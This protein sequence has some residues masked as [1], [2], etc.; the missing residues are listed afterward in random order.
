MFKRNL[1]KSVIIELQ[2]NEL[3]KKYLKVDCEK[4]EV[5]FAIRPNNEIGFYH[6]GG[7]LFSFDEKNK[8]R[9]HFKYASVIN[10]TNKDYLTEVE[11]KDYKLIS[12]FC[13]NYS[14]IKENCKHYSGVED[15]GIS[16]V[17]RKH[18][19]FSYPSNNIIVL[20]IEV[21][22]EAI[23][24]TNGRKQDIIDILLFDTNTQ[25]LK[26]IEAKHYSNS[27]IWAENIPKVINQIKRYE[28]QIAKKKTEIIKAYTEYVTTINE[29]FKKNIPLPEKIEEKVTLL[30]FGFDRDQQKGRLTKLIL[31]KEAYKGY[32]VYPIG[33]IKKI[34]L[35]NLW[36]VK[37]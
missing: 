31:E 20:D 8:F 24:K 19:F 21:A 25:T 30:I 28:K 36:K 12:D 9:T 18:S 11:L 16:E 27:E 14:R 7:R 17:Y 5:F 23:D 2:A 13:E 26:F 32:V 29:I 22:F 10:E 3:W 37:P 35:K 6:K 4:Q 33:E 1:D 34:V 15:T